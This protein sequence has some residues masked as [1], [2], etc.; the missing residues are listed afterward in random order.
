[1]LDRE[2]QWRGFVGLHGDAFIGAD[3]IAF[4]LG[5]RL[6]AERKWGFARLGPTVG[7]YAEG[8]VAT[9]A[10]SGGRGAAPYVSGGLSVGIA[11]WTGTSGELEVKLTGGGL[12]RLDGEKYHAFMA[13]VQFAADFWGGGR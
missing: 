1:M 12:V 7:A 10:G 6:T 8:G 5:A 13:G 11:G 3:R 4:L 9:E 2:R